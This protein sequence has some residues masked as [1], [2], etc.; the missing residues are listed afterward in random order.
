[1]WPDAIIEA[2]RHLVFVLL[3]ALVLLPACSKKEVKRQSLDSKLAV[4]AFELAEAMRAAYTD[5]NFRGLKKYCTE[6]AYDQIIREIKRF[7]SVQLVFTPR[8]VDIEQDSV[9]LNV[10]WQGTWT[11]EG[12]EK[13]SQGMAVLELQ[14]TP[15]KLIRIMRANPFAQPE[16]L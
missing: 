3:A 9:F 8:W 1:M 10:S 7:E 11:V 15:L 5:L 12:E 16:L 6:D 13:T 4:E 2:V 14:G